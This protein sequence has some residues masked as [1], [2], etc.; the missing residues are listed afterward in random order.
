MKRGTAEHEQKGV[1]MPRLAAITLAAPSPRPASR[2]RVR[3][4]VKYEFT[5]PV[6]NAT[7]VSSSKTL[8]VSQRKN[9]SAPPRW[10]ARSTGNAATSASEAGASDG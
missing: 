4:G 7:S 9:C 1:T 2:A 6:T 10:L 8:G 5:I 3:S